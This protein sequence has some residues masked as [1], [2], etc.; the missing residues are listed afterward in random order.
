MV[1]G[2]K[3]GPLEDSGGFHG[4]EGIM[5]ALADPSHHDHAEHSAWVAQITGSA[6][7][8]DLAFLDVAAVNR[9]APA[10]QLPGRLPA[11]DRLHVVLLRVLQRGL[12]SFGCVVRRGA[13]PLAGGRGWSCGACGRRRGAGRRPSRSLRCSARC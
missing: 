6:E 4:Y 11:G 2:A 10:G 12:G 13:E 3:H 1:D 8:F 5:G 7:P 9:A